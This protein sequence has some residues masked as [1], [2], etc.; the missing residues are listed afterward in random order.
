MNSEFVG[1]TNNETTH[2]INGISYLTCSTPSESCNMLNSLG[3]ASLST[4]LA[5]KRDMKTRK[6]VEMKF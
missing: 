1:V 4:S 6:A 3:I 2:D 5:L